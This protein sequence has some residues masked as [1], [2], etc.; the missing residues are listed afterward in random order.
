MSQPMR[1]IEK[2]G[3]W[4]GRRDGSAGS[5]GRLRLTRAESR[6]QGRENLMKTYETRR[7]AFAYGWMDVPELV[8]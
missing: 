1:T 8:R 7:P 4:P 3:T 6:G 2:H 5:G